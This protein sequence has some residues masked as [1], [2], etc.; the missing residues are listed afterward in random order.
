MNIQFFTVVKV[1]NHFVSKK[2]KNFG[3]T[4]YVFITCKLNLVMIYY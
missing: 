3:R 2:G 4:Y 1:N